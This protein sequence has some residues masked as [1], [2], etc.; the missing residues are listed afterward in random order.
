MFTLQKTV[1][2][3]L[4]I[5]VLG[6]ILT[7]QGCGTD[8]DNT[9]STKLNIKKNGV[10]TLESYLDFKDKYDWENRDI[11]EK[12]EKDYIMTNGS[13]KYLPRLGFH[14]NSTNTSSQIYG[15]LLNPCISTEEYDTTKIKPKEYEDSLVLNRDSYNSLYDLDIY[16][17]IQK[18]KEL[19]YIS[20]KKEEQKDLCL[21]N[22]W[23]YEGE[24]R[25]GST[26]NY[27]YT[28]KLRYKAEDLNRII[29]VYEP[30]T[31]AVKSP[32]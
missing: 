25:L 2:R 10:I 19:G 30:H 5:F 12:I 21:F 27:F 18:L 16:F 28:N 26:L 29:E 3:L 7:I 6:S 14:I 13:K 8:S 4:S 22:Q 20:K 11:L 17:N 23:T 15:F 31:P 32:L 9:K 1:S 24:G